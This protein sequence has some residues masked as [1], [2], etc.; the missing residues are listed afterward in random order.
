[1]TQKALKLFQLLLQI[2][3]VYT[4]LDKQ[5]LMPLLCLATAYLIG[6]Y[7]IDSTITGIEEAVEAKPA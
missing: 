1:M 6:K 3:A 4:I 5:F 2:F 7:A